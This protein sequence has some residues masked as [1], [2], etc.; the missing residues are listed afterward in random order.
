MPAFHTCPC[1][2]SSTATDG[3]CMRSRM[4]VGSNE[5]RVSKIRPLVIPL[6]SFATIPN[7][8]LWVMSPRYWTD[9]KVVRE[10]WWTGR[11]PGFDPSPVP[12]FQ[13]CSTQKLLD[14]LQCTNSPWTQAERTN[15]RLSIKVLALPVHSSS[16]ESC[17]DAVWNRS[18]L[19][20]EFHAVVRLDALILAKVVLQ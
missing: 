14:P 7:K 1:K 5:C 11:A 4:N 18:S 13:T 20:D 3:L 17:L 9:R 15:L 6:N 10:K 19:A 8:W 16:W 12:I 2:K